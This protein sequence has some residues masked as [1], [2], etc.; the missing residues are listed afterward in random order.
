MLSRCALN[1]EGRPQVLHLRV[2]AGT[3]GG[4]EKT[5]LNSP[6]FIRSQ[7]FDASVAYLCSPRDPIGESLRARALAADCLF[8]LL[9]DHGPFDVRLI[10]RVAALCRKL[11]IDILQSHDYKSNV[12]AWCVR[13]L[14][15]CRLVTMLHGWT[16]MTGRMPLYKRID[17]HFLRYFETLICVS[18]DLYEECQRL[19]IPNHRLHYVPNAIDTE[20]FRRVEDLR[21]AKASLCAR[22]DRFLIGSIGRLS[23]E[24]GLFELIHAVAS[25]Q[26]QGLPLDLWIAGEG[27]DRPRL[28][29]K[30]QACAQEDSMRLLGQV[31]DLRPFYQAMDLFVLNSHREGL[32]NVLLEAMAMET[33]AIATNVGGIA[34]LIEPGKT[35]YLIETDQEKGLI[36]SIQ[37]AVRD[38]NR[39]AVMASEARRR[40]VFQYGFDARMQ[41]IAAIYWNMLSKTGR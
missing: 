36:Q 12:I 40:V 24:K 21:S 11:K 37:A 5:I 13:K 18:K 6:R 2:C 22:P 28:A 25:L 9:E 4:P 10:F 15:R 31:S 1:A 30:I 39:G 8:Y 41:K 38:P 29:H 7:G 16:D 23:P 33:P 17:Q 32:P 27:P 20:S 19:G 34:D 3:G 26:K 35:G 14:V